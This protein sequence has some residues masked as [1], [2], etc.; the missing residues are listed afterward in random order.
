MDQGGWYDLDS[1]EFKQLDNITYVA[2]MG[3][4][5]QGRNAISLRCSR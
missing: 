4:P 1:K 2:A 3:P 5:S